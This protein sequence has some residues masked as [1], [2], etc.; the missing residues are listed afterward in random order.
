VGTFSA[1]ASAPAG[2]APS[3]TPVASSAPTPAPRKRRLGLGAYLTILGVLFALLAGAVWASVGYLYR[4]LYSP[5]A[6]VERYL[7]LLVD[8][9]AADALAIPGVAVD[10]AA[11]E[12]AGLPATASEALLR[13]DALAQLSGVDV[14]AET[15]DAETGVTRVTAEYRA[16]GYDGTTTFAVERAGSIGVAPTWRFATSPLAVLDLTVRGSMSFD[17]NGFAIDK[18]QVSVDGVDADPT[19]AVPLLVFSP[20][21]YSVA[22]DTAISATPGVVVLSDSPFQNVSVTVQAQATD[23][24]VE[25]VQE[26]VNEF[27]TDCASQEV[28]Q[29]T[30]CPFGFVLQ[31]RV[32]S[33]PDWSIKTYPKIDVVPDGAGWRIPATEAVAHLDVDV[34]SL[35]DGA[36]YGVSEDVGFAVTADITVLPDGTASIVVSGP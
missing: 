10:S 15:T 33:L 16:A 18:R 30:A 25:V 6:F 7:G 28:L 4:E 22:V 24:F 1:R 27:L 34:Q 20:G 35:F 23:Q 2:V 5:T 26:R 9:R 31:D 8:G 36:V 17:V 29:P 3:P 14:V 12:E 11:L 21:V 13:R 32:V 19:A